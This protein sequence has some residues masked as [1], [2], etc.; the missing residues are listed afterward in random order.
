MVYSTQELMLRLATEQ[1][2]QF[3]EQALYPLQNRVLSLAARYEGDIALTG[4]TALSRFYFHHRLSED[5]DLFTKEADIR[6]FAAAIT[7]D[8]AAA[9]L[10]IEQEKTTPDFARLFAG[11][12]H[13]KVELCRDLPRI[14]PI[15]KTA[16]GFFVHTLRDIAGNKIAAFEDRAE[17]KDLI[18]LYYLVQR[19]GWPALFTAADAKRVAPPYE[20]LRHLPTRRLQG[21]V[22]LLHEIPDLDR[23]AKTAGEAVLQEL[24][25]KVASCENEATI[26]N[27]IARLLWDAP[28]ERRRLRSDNLAIIRRR[29]AVLSEPKR[30]AVYKAVRRSRYSARPISSTT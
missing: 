23:F 27:T 11:H 28:P 6:A 13:M 3:Y 30:V 12:Q 22:L 15:R 4:G 20:Y 19:L 5:I 29:A 18:D 16:E 10:P 25:K 21:D 24:K 1:E 7:S 17:Q 14:D 8:F 9:G 26:S 2:R